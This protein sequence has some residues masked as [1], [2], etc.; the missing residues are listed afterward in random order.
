[1][2]PLLPIG[3]HRAVRAGCALAYVV[4][5]VGRTPRW[6]RLKIPG[7]GAPGG[8]Q[9]DRDEDGLP[10][11]WEMKF[12]PTPETAEAQPNSDPDL[13]GMTNYEEWKA[14]TSP[15][16][17]ASR[18]TLDLLVPTVDGWTLGFWG[19]TGRGYQVEVRESMDAG[20]WRLLEQT[21][22]LVDDSWVEILDPTGS[23]SER[24]Y[25]LLLWQYP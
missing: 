6:Y 4:R 22:V 16:E 7:V 18:L 21:D 3:R 15:I 12:W 8:Q 24:Y 1:M 9:M 13:D 10:D 20:E 5:A 14:G 25:R 19:L 17:G 2:S 23:D 11:E